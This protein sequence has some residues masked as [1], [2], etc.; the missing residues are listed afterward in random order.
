MNK[1]ELKVVSFYFSTKGNEGSY[2][3]SSSW[4]TLWL[5][6]KSTSMLEKS[7]S[8]SDWSRASTSLSPLLSSPMRRLP[9]SWPYS[10]SQTATLSKS[11]F[12]KLVIS[13][14]SDWLKSVILFH[15]DG[16]VLSMC[17]CYTQCCWLNLKVFYLF[18]NILIF[19]GKFLSS[20]GD[21]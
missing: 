21:Y 11:S 2:L 14:P 19:Q 20:C 5:Q 6:P 15:S 12:L 7:W 9:S 10:P 3:Q 16:L 17:A 8:S 4:G 13:L 1:C 18:C